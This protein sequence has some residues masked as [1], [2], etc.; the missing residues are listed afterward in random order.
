MSEKECDRFV[1]TQ[2]LIDELLRY[3]Q[4]EII[5]AI[6]KVFSVDTK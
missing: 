1:E 4:D 6:E 2:E 3:N 5:D